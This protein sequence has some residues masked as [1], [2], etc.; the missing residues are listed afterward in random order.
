VST[1][2]WLHRTTRF[3]LL[4][5]LLGGSLAAY[6]QETPLKGTQVQTPNASQ[7]TNLSNPGPPRLP[8]LN[9]QV[10]RATKEGQVEE[11]RTLL[12]A[13][14]SPNWALWWAAM[15]GR[16]DVAELAL[17][18]GPALTGQNDLPRELA[19]D[20]LGKRALAAAL[21]SSNKGFSEQNLKGKRGDGF[22]E[23]IALLL[24]HGV[25]AE[26]PNDLGMTPLMEAAMFGNAKATTILL[27]H[28][29][30]P[31]RESPR[32]STALREAAFFGHGAVVEELLKAGASADLADEKKATPLLNA[33]CAGSEEALALLTGAA[34]DAWSWI[35]GPRGKDYLLA[36]KAL[37]K[38][39]ADVNASAKNGVTALMAASRAGDI[40]IVKELLDAGAGLHDADD[41]GRTALMAAVQSGKVPLVVL[42]LER[43][44][45]AKVV[46]LDGTTALVLAK[47]G[48]DPE[49]V[50]VLKTALE[51]KEPAEPGQPAASK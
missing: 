36:V 46:A 16:A 40:A 39:D 10:A 21:A 51:C 7:A 22:N 48:K 20:D 45:D 34:S 38:A 33:C 27:E 3:A 35:K 17:Q 43:G 23:I 1:R 37:I 42:L 26:T 30:K 6:V 12:L 31:D 11:V 28:G 9:V 5:L 24:D 29:A 44:A 14:G 41:L 4:G 50:R 15:W 25:A 19:T 2:I 47:R 49:M 32:G 13:G 8:S 18:F